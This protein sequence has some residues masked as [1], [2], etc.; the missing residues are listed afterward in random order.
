MKGIWLA[1]SNV[2]LK[3]PESIN[4]WLNIANEFEE[5][6]NFPNCLGATD[7]KHVAMNVQRMQAPHFTIIR[8]FTV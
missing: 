6:W 5:N 1:L 2:Y 7:G 4:E 8:T 3:A